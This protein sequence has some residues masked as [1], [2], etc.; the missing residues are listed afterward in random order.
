M[1]LIFNKEKAGMLTIPVIRTNTKKVSAEKQAHTTPK[2]VTIVP[3][4]NDITIDQWNSI[5]DIMKIKM[6]LSKGWLTVKGAKKNVNKE[7]K[8]ETYLSEKEFKE[9]SAEE[10]EVYIEECY[11]VP[12]L[13]KWKEAGVK[14]GVLPKLNSR[15][16]KL[17]NP[18]ADDLAMKIKR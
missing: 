9:M 10:Q 14:D 18:D 8:K 5:K 2:S 15:I 1:I 6:Y 12:L 13:R 17:E 7:T 4:T 16:E 11:Q 3:G